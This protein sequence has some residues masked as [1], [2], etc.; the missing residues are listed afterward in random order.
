MN[1]GFR[2]VG[3]VRRLRALERRLEAHG[4]PFLA[5][6]AN[7]GPY[8]HAAVIALAELIV[9]TTLAGPARW[10]VGLA[11]LP[12]YAA[13]VWYLSPYRLTWVDGSVVRRASLLG[14][15]TLDLQQ[16]TSVEHSISPGAGGADVV[17]RDRAGTRVR[18]PRVPQTELLRQ[19]I[20][21]AITPDVWFRAKSDRRSATDLGMGQRER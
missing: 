3:S 16:L 14:E 20:G 9:F 13:L 18:V 1:G 21:R 19:A 12:G 15:T 4:E 2:V 10:W 17:L 8:A 7:G 11:F 5:E 6:A